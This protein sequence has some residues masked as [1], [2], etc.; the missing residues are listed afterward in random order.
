M[1]QNRKVL[2]TLFI[3]KNEE[4]FHHLAHLNIFLNTLSRCS[5][6]L[7]RGA[8]VALGYELITTNFRYL[9][10]SFRCAISLGMPIIMKLAFFSAAR[11]LKK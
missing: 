10:S 3:F 8:R 7:E 11:V 2:Y 6:H 4:N 5:Y 1:E 9:L